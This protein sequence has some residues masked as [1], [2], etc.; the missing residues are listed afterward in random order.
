[1]RGAFDTQSPLN[2]LSVSP[3][4]SQWTVALTAERQAGCGVMQ[5]RDHTASLPKVNEAL[6]RTAEQQDFLL[7]SW[8]FAM[9]QIESLA[10][11]LPTY[12]NHLSL[13]FFLTLSLFH[14]RICTHHMLFLFCFVFFLLQRFCK[15]SLIQSWCAHAS[16]EILHACGMFCE[17]NIFC[18]HHF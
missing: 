3:L 15:A 13:S 8:V 6:R 12:W 9:L 10:L 2:L 17:E 5:Q 1:M 16:A 11:M 18:L 14:A 4:L 7:A